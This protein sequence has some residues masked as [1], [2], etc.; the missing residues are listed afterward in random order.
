RRI[1]TT[2]AMT[3]PATTVSVEEWVAA[4]AADAAR[5]GPVLPLAAL[6]NRLRETRHDATLWARAGDALTRNGFAEPAAALLAAALQQHP[7]DAE[8][9]Y[10]RGNALRV[11]QRH[12]EAE[13]DFRAALQ[14]APGHANATL[15]LAYMLRGDGRIEAA[16]ETVLAQWHAEPG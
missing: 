6:V 9:H 11:S 8:L 10:L 3:T 2:N 4:F 13:R 15:S 14:S 16:G 12:D 7:R 1:L 5:R